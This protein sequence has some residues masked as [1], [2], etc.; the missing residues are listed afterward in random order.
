MSQA[1]CLLTQVAVIPEL[2]LRL[3]HRC[4]WLQEALE[5]KREGMY[6]GTLHARGVIPA[7]LV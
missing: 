3:A 1:G 6:I 4:K 2:E 5:A 7:L